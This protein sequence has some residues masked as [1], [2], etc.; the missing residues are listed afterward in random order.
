[1]EFRLELKIR[2]FEKQINIRD[3]IMLMGSCFTDHISR[4]LQLH[5]FNVSE[6]PN[7]IL[8]NPASISNAVSSYIINKKYNPENLFL[9]NGL[10]TSWEHHSDYSNPEQHTALENINR[11]VQNAHSFFKKANWLIITLGSSFVY[12]LKDDSLGGEAGLVAANCH[13]VPAQYFNHRLLSY[14]EVEINLASI[15]SNATAF[16]PAIKIVFTIS[17][18][19][20][21]REGLVENNRSKALLHT[22]VHQMTILHP[23]VTY[24]PS[25]ELVIDDLRDYRFFAEDMV[26]PNYQATNYVWEKFSDSLIDDESRIIMKQLL[27]IHHAKNHRPLHPGTEQHKQFLTTMFEKTKLFSEQYPFLNM[28]EELNYFASSQ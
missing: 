14:K 1:M 25:Y 15:I 27:S 26:H 21:F 19:R 5:K 13:K 16:N 18:V 22:A 6:N 12:Q 8:F 3:K 11:S 20:H 10:W 17:P 9:F 2:P 4:R 28:E 7:G 23:Q 24:F